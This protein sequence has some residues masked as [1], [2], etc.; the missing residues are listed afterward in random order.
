MA[1]QEPKPAQAMGWRLHGSPLPASPRTAPR[2]AVPHISLTN[3]SYNSTQ[4]L[5]PTSVSRTQ[6]LK[7][8]CLSLDPNSIKYQ[9]GDLGQVTLPLQVT[10]SSYGNRKTMARSSPDCQEDLMRQ[11]VE[12]VQM[13]LCNSWWWWCSEVTAVS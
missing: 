9:L 13:A 10:V 7:S 8:E 12:D 6:I 5:V 4:G 2:V 1:T 3:N 11:N